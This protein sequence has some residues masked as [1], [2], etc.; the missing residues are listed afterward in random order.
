VRS[1]GNKSFSGDDGYRTRVRPHPTFFSKHERDCSLSRRF[2]KRPRLDGAPRSLDQR[3]MRSPWRSFPPELRRRTRRNHR[4]Q[5]H[6]GD[7]GR[8][9]NGNEVIRA[10]F[11]SNRGETAVFDRRP[12]HDELLFGNVDSF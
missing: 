2:V 9:S 3:Q 5:N 10:G 8:R 6:A 11:Q 4:L 7:F 12:V 1:R